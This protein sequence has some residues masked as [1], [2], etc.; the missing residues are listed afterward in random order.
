IFKYTPSK[1][2]EKNNLINDK[3]ILGVANVWDERKGLDDFF[4]LSTLVDNS[5]KI[6]LVGMTNKQKNFIEKNHKNI[7]C[8]TNTK[9][10]QELAEIY[11]AADVFVNPSREET[12]GM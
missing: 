1:F 9:N 12:F 2:R 8:I 3:I 7:I 5:Y 10:V 4:E 11:S 6:V